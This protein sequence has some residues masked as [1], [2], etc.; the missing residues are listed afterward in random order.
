VIDGYHLRVVEYSHVV[1]LWGGGPKQL[2]MRNM[3]LDAVCGAVRP[4]SGDGSLS[5]EGLQTKIQCR[6]MRASAA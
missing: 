1:K 2:E 4:N 5:K 6:L 3:D